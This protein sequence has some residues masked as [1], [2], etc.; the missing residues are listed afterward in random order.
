MTLNNL[1]NQIIS[2]ELAIAKQKD[3]WELI[4]TPT[5]DEQKVSPNK[6]NIVLSFFFISIFI[7]CLLSLIKESILGSI[8]DLDLIKSKLNAN[9][10]DVISLEDDDMSMRILDININ[11]VLDEKINKKFIG[12]IG[13][14][15][16]K[17]NTLITN[18]INSNKDMKYIDI[19]DSDQIKDIQNL[20]IFIEAGKITYKEIN[21]INKYLYLYPSKNFYWIYEKMENFSKIFDIAFLKKLSGKFLNKILRL[22]YFNQF[23]WNP[24]YDYVKI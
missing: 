24:P 7:S 6:K 15:Y 11:K 20:V 23:F 13:F 8:D 16:S 21:K 5:V 9:F 10:L 22:K 18:Y 17:T 3:P 12:N 19:F 2:S 4:L 1:K 14:Y